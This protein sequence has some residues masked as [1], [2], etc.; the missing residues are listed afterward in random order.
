MTSKLGATIAALVGGVALAASPALAQMHGGGGHMGGGGGFHASGRTGGSF[1]SGTSGF[2]GGGF[3]GGGFRDGGFRGGFHHRFCCGFGP[4]FGFWGDP[5]FWGGL[6]FVAGYDLAPY[7]DDYYGPYG[8][9][10]ADGPPEGYA[11]GPPAGYDCNGW[12]WDAAQNRY[13]AA[14]VAC[15]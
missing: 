13:V 12:R 4:G 7:A 6:G 5:F 15:N 10:Y 11:P 2:R 9:P 1:H 8:D 3:R 14:K